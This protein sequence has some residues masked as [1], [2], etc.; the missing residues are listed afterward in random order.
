MMNICN[1]LKHSGE[2]LK[3]IIESGEVPISRI[4]KHLNVD[5]STIYRSFDK[6]E[7]PIEFLLSVGKAIN[8][9]MSEFFPEVI[10]AQQEPP[11]NYGAPRSYTELVDE[12]KYWKDKYIDVL[13]KYNKLLNERLEEQSNRRPYGGNKTA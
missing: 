8:K 10:Q 2:I 3:K 9:D 6:P 5:R 1:M 12:S 4:A 11:S 7:I 13:E